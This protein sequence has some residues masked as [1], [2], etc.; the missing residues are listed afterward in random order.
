MP[1][2]RID[3]DCH[4]FRQPFTALLTFQNMGNL[5]RMKKHHLQGPYFRGLPENVEEAGRLQQS[6]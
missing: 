1:P 5:S 2:I 4:Y 3:Q 6:E